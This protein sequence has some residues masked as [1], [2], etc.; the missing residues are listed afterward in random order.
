MVDVAEIVNRL[1]ELERN[2]ATAERERDEYRRL[3]LETMERCRKL[4]LRAAFIE[5]GT[6]PKRRLPV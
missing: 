3:Y 5:V 1:D 2:F 6:P 4:E